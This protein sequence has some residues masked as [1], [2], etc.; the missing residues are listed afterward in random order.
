MKKIIFVALIGLITFTAQAQTPSAATIQASTQPPRFGITANQDN[1]GRK[2]TYGQLFRQDS[3]QTAM[4]TV[5]TSLYIPANG[6]NA[7]SYL[8]ANGQLNITGTVSNTTL[9]LTVH[10]SCVLAFNTTAYSHVGDELN[11]IILNTTGTVHTVYLLGYSGLASVWQTAASG[12]KISL[13]SGKNAVLHFIFDG[14]LWEEE[15]RCIH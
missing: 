6:A 1:T 10:D 15:T 2:V 13:N 9:Y 3:T 4:D 5:L 14:T 8:N 11:L 7:A 12:T